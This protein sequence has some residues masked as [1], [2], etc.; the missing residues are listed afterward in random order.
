MEQ[1]L[2]L[3]EMYYRLN[4]YPAEMPKI[5]DTQIIRMG[6][7]FLRLKNV[8]ETQIAKITID[9]Y[10]SVLLKI[11]KENPFGINTV[12]A[13]EKTAEAIR[14]I[15]AGLSPVISPLTV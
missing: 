11:S 9:I 4:I 5:A 10:S 14:P 3:Y 6:G 2:W 12:M 1:R 15:A 7:I 13:I 8:R